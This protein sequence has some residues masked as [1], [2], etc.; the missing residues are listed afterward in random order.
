MKTLSILALTI[1]TLVSTQALAQSG[2]VGTGG[3]M[4][5]LSS[6]EEIR[7]T[8]RQILSD[9]SENNPERN[10][11]T[12]A[13]VPAGRAKNERVRKMLMRIRYPFIGLDWRKHLEE[14][15]PMPPLSPADYLKLS[16]L[17]FPENDFCHGVGEAH[18]NAEASVSKFS[19]GADI[20]FSIKA[21]ASTPRGTTHQNAARPR[22]SRGGAFEWLRRKRSGRT[23]D[24]FHRSLPRDHEAR[25]RVAPVPFRD[26]FDVDRD[27]DLQRS[28]DGEPRALRQLALSAG[29]GPWPDPID[30]RDAAAP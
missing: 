29:F 17:D 9:L 12:T 7:Q 20:C 22:R 10:P 26:D 21:L 6:A 14:K 16:R 30:D 11:L 2:G 3:G 19:Y 27:V 5:I 23:A 25:R 1:A 18:T 4:R 15:K 13:L 28:L 24:V 8:V